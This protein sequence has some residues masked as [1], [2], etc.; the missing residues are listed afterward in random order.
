VWTALTKACFGQNESKRG[1][2]TT[3]TNSW[4]CVASFA[5]LSVVSRGN[6]RASHLEPPVSVLHSISTPLDYVHKAGVRRPDFLLLLQCL[7]Q[8]VLSFDECGDWRFQKLIRRTSNL[9]K[10]AFWQ[11]GNNVLR[12]RDNDGSIP[13]CCRPCL[14][15]DRLYLT[16]LACPHYEYNEQWFCAYRGFFK[17]FPQSAT[18]A[19]VKEEKVAY[20]V[21]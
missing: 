14:Q 8:V 5:V 6:G 21:R 12:G 19:R 2:G 10:E 3:R 4:Y 7:I 20:Y 13:V 18:W 9:C 16:K 1:L 15:G 11:N 17:D